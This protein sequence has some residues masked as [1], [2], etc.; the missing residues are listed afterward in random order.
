MREKHTDIESAV[1]L[2]GITPACAG[3]T[4]IFL[5]SSISSR[6][7]PRV[8]GKNVSS[9]SDET[10]RVGSP[11][12]VR[13]KRFKDY[14]KGQEL[15]ITPACAGKTSRCHCQT[16]P[17]WDHPRVCGKNSSLSISNIL[18]TG[19]PP[20]VREKQCVVSTD[21]SNSGITPA[22]AGK[23]P[24]SSFQRLMVRDHPRVCGKNKDIL[25]PFFLI[26]GS[27]PRVREK[28]GKF[29]LEDGST[30]I[31]PACAGKTLKDPN[32]IKTFLSS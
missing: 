29:K 14:S 31:T 1:S 22:C 15:R 26:L 7:H 16:L 11:P 3:K 23:T 4:S 24:V 17:M 21:L 18:R 27:P 32:E 2:P 8:C 28:P 9:K 19:S 13:E 25:R 12:R 20:R 10:A 6:D 30:G 5:C